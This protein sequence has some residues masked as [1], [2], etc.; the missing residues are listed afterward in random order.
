MVL[1]LSRSPRLPDLSGWSS[2]SRL[3]P[4]WRRPGQGQDERDVLDQ[5]VTEPGPDQLVVR[6][7]QVPPRVR[8]LVADAERA[9]AAEAPVQFPHHLPPVLRAVQGGVLDGQQ[10]VGDGPVVECQR[11]PSR[12]LSSTRLTREQ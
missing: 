2:G 9:V 1:I 10:D 8:E 4:G 6:Q 12:L 7:L 3:R 5:A 11:S